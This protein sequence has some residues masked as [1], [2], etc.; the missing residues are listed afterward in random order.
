MR[1]HVTVQLRGEI[2]DDVV[3]PVVDGMRIGEHPS[4]VVP[5]PGLDLVFQTDEDEAVRV[6][7][8]RLVDGQAVEFGVDEVRV[9][10]T[11]VSEVL[12]PRTP[13]WRGDIALPVLM[14]AAILLTLGGQTARDVLVAKAD[15]SA[16]VARTVEAWLLPPSL[17]FTSD[18]VQPPAPTV[19]VD[20]DAPR[21]PWETPR[22]RYVEH[23]PSG[24]PA[25]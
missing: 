24:A 17:R 23:A 9:T 2:V 6:R 20:P 12:L 13:I 8:H 21:D 15:V 22:A 16:G 14:L 11:P 1:L 3:V 25:R 5:F 18:P 19:A 7:E 10:V 4:A